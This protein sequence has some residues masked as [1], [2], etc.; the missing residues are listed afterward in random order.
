MKVFLPILL[1]LTAAR[2]V[3]AEDQLAAVTFESVV[4]ARQLINK[5][6]LSKDG[7]DVGNIADIIIDRGHGKVA[8]VTARTRRSTDRVPDVFI[9]PAALLSFQP[10]DQAISSK[11]TIDQLKQLDG[12]DAY[13]TRFVE[14]RQ[15]QKMYDHYGTTPYWKNDQ[16]PKRLNLIT[17][18]E[19][20]GRIVRDTDW[21]VVGRVQ[22]VLL[23]TE[24]NWQV[25]YVSLSHLNDNPDSDERV[26]VP[27][28]AFALQRLSPTWLL[29]LPDDT[30]LLKKR[31]RE[32]NWPTQI[33]RGW[34]EYTHV[35]YGTGA[36]GGL[37]DL[38]EQDPE[39]RS[40]RNTKKNKSNGRRSGR[41]DSTS[42]S[43][44]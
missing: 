39:H 28:S 7:V 44:D 35:R 37:Q 6:V 30:S 14:P 25:A 26:A 13:P 19:M 23:A 5:V 38:S 29:D 24:R 1:L 2:P 10:G 18:D 21:D 8:F 31:F 34:I 42:K 3:S 27:L 15:M 17:V 11:A 12:T 22:E 33:H 43:K 9:L 4:P 16:P 36:L 32:D 41:S 20:D 40:D